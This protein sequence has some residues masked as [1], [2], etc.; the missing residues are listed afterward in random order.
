M[1]VHLKVGMRSVEKAIKLTCIALAH[2]YEEKNQ[3]Y[4]AAPLFLQALTMSDP[5]SCHTAILSVS[6]FSRPH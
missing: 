6:L 5:S 2:H 3:H 4:L 1:E